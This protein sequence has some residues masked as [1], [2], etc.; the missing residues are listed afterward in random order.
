MNQA[1]PFLSVAMLL[2]S[3]AGCTNYVGPADANGNTTI[4]G[5]IGT[6]GGS[7]THTVTVGDNSYSPATITIAVLD[8]VTWV[9]SGTNPHSVTFDDGAHDSGVRTTGTYQRFFGAAGSY[10]YQ[11]T[12]TSDTL[13]IG[14][15]VVQ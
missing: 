3:V 1:R 11:S 14:T 4:G 7:G 5:S 8:T 12:T 10:R 6:G 15:V 2:L 13:M 9:W